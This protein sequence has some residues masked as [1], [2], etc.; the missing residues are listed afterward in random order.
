MHAGKM[1]DVLGITARVVGA[2]AAVVVAATACGGAPSPPPGDAEADYAA[3]ELAPIPPAEPVE[4]V[5]R[6]G[7]VVAEAAVARV[8]VFARPGGGHPFIRLEHHGSFGEPRVFLVQEWR[9]GW[10]RALLPMEPNGSEGWIRA[11]DVELSEHPY[12]IRVDLGARRLTVLDKDRVVLR[13]PV[14]VGMPAAPT[15]T[16]LYFT[17]VLAEP[18]D[19]GG[20]YGRFAYGLS[21]YSEVYEEFAGGDG[22]VAIHGTNAPWLIGQAVSHGCVR[23]DNAAITRLARLVPLGTP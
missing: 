17:T 4:P 16:G 1:S 8:P 21:A 19:P 3:V 18:D 2:V 13:E 15:P 23:M 5:E 7:S 6:P 9:G 10:L 12:R 22:Q 11:R 14:A 20:P